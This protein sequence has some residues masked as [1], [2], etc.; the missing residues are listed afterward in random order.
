MAKIGEQKFTHVICK[1][2]TFD[3]GS[4]KATF[5]TE[6]F[7]EQSVLH[8]VVQMTKDIKVLHIQR[9]YED[10]HV[11]DVEPKFVDGKFVLVEGHGLGHKVRLPAGIIM[12]IGDVYDDHPL[13]AIKT[14]LRDEKMQSWLRDDL[15]NPMKLSI[16]ITTKYFE[17]E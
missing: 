1:E 12:R 3:D 6:I 2:H 16:A 5:F 17:A 15:K 11:I 8:A 7:S 9:I 4:G 14:L 13:E 10:G